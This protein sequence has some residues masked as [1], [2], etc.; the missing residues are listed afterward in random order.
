MAVNSQR[1]FLV[2]T[3]RRRARLGCILH[4]AHHGEKIVGINPTVAS[5]HRL[6]TRCARFKALD[7]TLFAKPYLSQ[8]R[9]V[10][11]RHH[12][13]FALKGHHVGHRPEDFFLPANVAWGA[14]K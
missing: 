9:P 12:I 14:G 11:Q 1:V 8:A 2:P 5:H 7:Q 13:I 4:K 3:L 10:H 6:A